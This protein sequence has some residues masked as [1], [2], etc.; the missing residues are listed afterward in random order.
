MRKPI[1][2]ELRGLKTPRE[3]VWEALLLLDALAE[4]RA[5]GFDKTKVQDHC[6]PMVSW[7]LV[8]DYLDDLEKAGWLK[9]VGGNGVSKGVMGKPIQFVLTRRQ[10]DAPRVSMKGAKVTQGQGTD[11]MWRAMKVLPGFDYT[12]IARAATLGTLVVTPQTAK[13]Y[14]AHLA[15]AGYLMCLKPSKPGTPARHRLINNT[16]PH[17]PCITRAK[18]V[19]DRNTGTFAQLETAQEVCDALE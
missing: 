11:A 19:F 12:D 7:T 10:A 4:L 2:M 17:A 13:S 15:R 14:V 3:R 1:Q 8:D 5:S 6:M 18:V 16:G 9:R